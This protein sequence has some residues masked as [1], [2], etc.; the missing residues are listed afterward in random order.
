VFRYVLISVDGRC[1]GP[2]AFARRHFKPGDV[3][4][5]GIGRLIHVVDVIQPEREDR[6]PVLVV[7][8]VR[9]GRVRPP[10]GG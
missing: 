9:H 4:P 5:S 2:A 8:L 10:A 1:L 6:L 3:I 7:E